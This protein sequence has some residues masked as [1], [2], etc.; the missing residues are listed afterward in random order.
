MN[1][2]QKSTNKLAKM[3][4]LAAISIVLVSIV[5]IPF[6]APV[7]FLEYDPADIPILLGTF[8]LGPWAGLILTIVTS[9]IQGLT[10]SAG[11]GLYGIIMHI[12]AT[13]ANCVVAGSIYFKKKNKKRAIIALAL[14][15][16][17]HTLIMIPANLFITPVFTGWP[18]SAVV[19][20]LPW[21]ILFNIV[22]TVV[23]AFLTFILY[24]R[25]S[26]ILHK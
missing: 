5:H 11:S 6:I 19:E 13:G 15:I 7:S 23:N 22:K 2:V 24:K 12:I 21:I 4:V 14:G 9:V 26:G 18:V 25:V 17:I 3:G 10:V 1:N 16:I 20:V 8:A